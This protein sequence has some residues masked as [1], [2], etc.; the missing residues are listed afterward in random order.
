MVTR[1]LD[2]GL[3]IAR[4]D[5][6]QLLH[7]PFCRLRQFLGRLRV[8]NGTAELQARLLSRFDVARVLLPELLQRVHL[9][10]GLV[11]VRVFAERGLDAVRG[12]HRRGIVVVVVVVVPVRELVLLP[13]V[14]Q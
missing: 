4:L 5:S 12:T 13:K 2:R 6:G 7:R 3:H 10:R 14:L 11:R 8:R 1:S 9:R